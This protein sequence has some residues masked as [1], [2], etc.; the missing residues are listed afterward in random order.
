MLFMTL[1]VAMFEFSWL[2]FV[3][4]TFHHAVRE[5]VRVAITGQTPPAFAGQHD[6]YIKSVIQTNSFGLLDTAALNAHVQVDYFNLDGTAATTPS[7]GNIVQVSIRCYDI[8]PITSLIR[9]RD[10]NGNLTPI[11]VSVYSSDRM[12]PFPDSQI[13]TRGTVA[14][15]TACAP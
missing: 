7:G 13:P 15:A 12:E 4:S 3:K 1:M 14:A 8:M 9:P 11:T 6:A 2:L 10:G 5:G